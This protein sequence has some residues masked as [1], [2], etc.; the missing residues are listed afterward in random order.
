MTDLTFPPLMHGRPVTAGAMAEAARQARLGCDAGLVTYAL[1]PDVVEAALVFA[2][3]VPLSRALSMLPLC[4]VGFQNAF[5]ALA[6]PEVAVHLEWAGGIR[7]NGASCGQLRVAASDR[8]PSAIPDWLIVAV[9]VP[10]LPDLEDMG[11]VPDRTVLYAEG[12]AEVDPGHLVEAWS[13]HT[14]HWINRWEADG[15]AALHAEWRG[16]A[17]GMGES[18]TE[19]GHTGV[20]L[21]VDEDFGMLLRDVNGE[22]HLIPLST[23]LELD[24]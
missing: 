14:L 12:C 23:L 10:L 13:R 7:V 22:T 11:T 6:P 3:E 20:F 18:M 5:G 1:G 15:A 2:P 9:S 4:A 24:P 19:N 16:L 17:H 8:D 21:G